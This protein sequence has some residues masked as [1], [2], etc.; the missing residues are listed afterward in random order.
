MY[1]CIC[2]PDPVR[3]WFRFKTSYISLLV[4]FILSIIFIVTLHLSKTARESR[5][6][7]YFVIGSYAFGISLILFYL[8]RFTGPSHGENF[9]D[10]YYLVYSYFPLIFIGIFGASALGLLLAV[11]S[12][13]P[14]DDPKKPLYFG[15]LFAFLIQTLYCLLFYFLDGMSN[16]WSLLGIPIALLISP[17]LY[18]SLFKVHLV[19]ERYVM[20]EYR[21]CSVRLHRDFYIFLLIVALFIFWIILK[22][23]IENKV[24]NQ[25]TS[26]V[27]KKIEEKAIDKVEEKV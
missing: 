6:L 20:R 14:T 7:Y 9:G 3:P 5:F 4:G 1:V 18:Y 23:C 12:F 13:K 24:G 11:R 26:E 22:K 21:L 15:L 17:L 8:A 19:K 16:F 25:A 2:L 10:H 27:F